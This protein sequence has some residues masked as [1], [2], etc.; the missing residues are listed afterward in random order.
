MFLIIV[1]ASIICLLFLV[2]I[3]HVLLLLLLICCSC[4]SGI[5]PSA[6]KRDVVS[7]VCCVARPVG[8]KRAKCMIHTNIC[9]LRHTAPRHTTPH[10]TAKHRVFTSNSRQSE[11]ARFSFD[12]SHLFLPPSN[13]KDPFHLLPF[14]P[15][16]LPPFLPSSLPPSNMKSDSC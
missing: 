9:C 16:S 11:A 7:G 10:R 5:C 1:M 3:I 13:I 6:C 2:I 15:S 12:R 4:S 8:T 14:L